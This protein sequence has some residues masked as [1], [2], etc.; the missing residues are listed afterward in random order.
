MTTP[1]ITGWLDRPWRDAL[2]AYDRAC[3]RVRQLQD[4]LESARDERQR[5][6]DELQRLQGRPV[7]VFVAPRQ[8][9]TTCLCDGDAACRRAQREGVRA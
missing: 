2:D 3:E 1:T 9:G 6:D 8:H 5:L 7:A 4:Q